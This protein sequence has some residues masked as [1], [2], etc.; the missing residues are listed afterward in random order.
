MT[1]LIFL[2]LLTC[3]L[4]LCAFEAR[5]ATPPNFSGGDGSKN[6]PYRISNTQDLEAL[7]KR[8]FR[9]EKDERGRPYGLGH[10]LQTMDVD[11][12]SMREWTPIGSSEERPFRGV[13]D[14]GGHRISTRTL[15]RSRKAASDSTTFDSFGLFGF[16]DGDGSETGI[17]KNVNLDSPDSSSLFRYRKGV[18]LRSMGSIAGCLIDGRL[19]NC[20]TRGMMS[21]SLPDEYT[22]TRDTTF[23][24]GIVGEVR[25]GSVEYCVNFLQLV[26]SY[27]DASAKVIGG[28]AGQNSGI[29]RAC[30][31]EAEHMTG[32]G[33]KEIFGGVVGSL[34]AGQVIDCSNTQYGEVVGRVDGGE[35]LY[36]LSSL[37]PGEVARNFSGGS[38]TRE[39]PFRIST[40]EDLDVLA[41]R[42]L[43]EIKYEDSPAYHT[44]HYRQ[45]AD[46]DLSAIPSWIPI[47]NFP[48]RNRKSAREFSGVYDGG[49]YTISNI[50]RDPQAREKG[51]Y[52]SSYG[53]FGVL[54]GDGVETGIV[55][56]VHMVNA[57]SSLR[58]QEDPHNFGVIVGYVASGRVQ[59]CSTEGAP[60]EFRVDGFRGYTGNGLHDPRNVGGIVGTMRAGL[61]ENCVS[62]MKIVFHSEQDERQFI[63][64]IAGEVEEGIVRNCRNEGDISMAAFGS[65]AGGIVGFFKNG[66]V[67]DCVNRGRLELE[68]RAGVE[69]G[70][71][72]GSFIDGEIV[73]SGNQG[74]IIVHSTE[75]TLVGGLAGSMRNKAGGIEESMNTG[76]ILVEIR[77]ES[78]KTD[79]SR[80]L[81][82][83]SAGSSGSQ[84][85][86]AKP[87]D[88][89]LRISLGGLAGSLGPQTFLLN[90][91]NVGNVQ[92]KVS[93]ENISSNIYMGGLVGALSVPSSRSERTVLRNA[94]ST[95]RLLL[96]ESPSGANVFAGF[97]VGG[98]FVKPK[99]GT[100]TSTLVL[101]SCYW[102]E[103]A[104]SVAGIGVDDFEDDSVPLTSQAFKKQESFKGWN[105][106]EI[107]MMPQK[108]PQTPSLRCLQGDK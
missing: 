30:A 24:G 42:L 92:G 106:D 58:C 21:Y 25:K 65:D 32:G 4:G 107:W 83:G 49:G 27:D 89:T 5:A 75:Y 91:A 57:F 44:S 47:G 46:I 81:P 79:A 71:L 10:Y 3:M 33:R 102:P 80:N 56:N 18:P 72:V 2:S 37:S 97:L 88:Y 28:V 87:N 108:N 68:G 69:V 86:S 6:D 67:S 43:E 52:A 74:A 53:L 54:R 55:K 95:G 7:A 29:V 15:T 60:L 8:V 93:G 9:G 36:F 100:K 104:R 105:F 78:K 41:E 51:A 63:G 62:G 1:L 17:V 19:Q 59:N 39:D 22:K 101:D 45:T 82:G 66:R 98:G 23:I 12:A 64:G 103:N 13:F 16:I 14:G 31:N 76:D 90:V 84:Y 99:A 34:A 85:A 73:R 11:M 70:G 96:E 50:R 20:T 40:A 48:T 77:H 61:I 38:G 94:F 35:V 26:V